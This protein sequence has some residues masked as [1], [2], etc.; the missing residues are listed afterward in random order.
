MA[1]NIALTKANLIKVKNSKEFSQKGFE[2]LDKKR[3]VLIKEMMSLIDKSKSIQEDIDK[4]FRE[5]YEALQMVNITMGEK[6]VKEIS[7]SISKEKEY[8]I[9]FK[10]VMGVEIPTIKFQP[11]KMSTQYGFFRTNSVLDMAIDKFRTV[12]DLI[13]ELAEVENSVF[14]LAMEIKKTQKRANGLE[15]IQIPKYEREIKVI[16]DFLAEKEREDFYRLKK[17]KNKKF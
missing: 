4:I 12:K 7:L 6:N 14:K 5:A 1:I 2:L 11:S 16:E 10:S 15:K 13:F 17:V 8:Q 9:L 3:T